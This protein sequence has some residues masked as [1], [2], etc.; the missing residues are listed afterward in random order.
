MNVQTGKQHRQSGYSLAELLTVVAMV[1][2]IS[3]VALPTFLKVIPQYRIRGA[4]SEIS[5]SLRLIRSKAVSTRS[6]WRMTV[7]PTNDEYWLEANTGGTWSPIGEDGR[8]LPTGSAVKKKSLGVDLMPA[9]SNIIVTFDRGGNVAA[10]TS[11]V[12]GVN[13]TWVRF[14]RYTLDVQTSGNIAITPSKV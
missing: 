5:A 13:N 2:I 10:A 6:S 7:D 14:N 11:I 9:G 1:G 8:T 4:A 3:M 12:V